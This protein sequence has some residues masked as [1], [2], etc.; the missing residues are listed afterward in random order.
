MYIKI[1]FMKFFYRTK[2]IA[3]EIYSKRIEIDLMMVNRCKNCNLEYI[4]KF[5]FCPN[6]GQKVNDQLTVNLLFYNTISNYLSVDARILKSFISLL[7]RPGHVAKEFVY[8]KRLQYLHPAQFYLF[9]SVLF[10]F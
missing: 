5:S 4:D 8:G 10:F 6:C 3:V 1:Y 7:F 2:L 9:V